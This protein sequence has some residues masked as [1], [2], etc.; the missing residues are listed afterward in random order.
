MLLGCR[1]IQ[2][3]TAVS[4][5]RITLAN[6]IVRDRVHTRVGLEQRIGARI[7]PNDTS[8]RFEDLQFHRTGRIGCERVVDYGAG[9]WIL[10]GGKLG[11]P[12]RRLVRAEAN[13]DSEVGTPDE[14]A[15]PPRRP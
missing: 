13:A 5:R 14:R 3:Q 2:G 4:C 15:V 9:R 12:R 10:G 11:W 7:G 6:A 1:P 8:S